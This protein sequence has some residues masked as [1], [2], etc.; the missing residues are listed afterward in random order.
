MVII[1]LTKFSVGNYRLAAALYLFLVYALGVFFKSAWSDDYSSLLDPEGHRVH[2]IKDG[3]LLH[4]ASIDFFYSHFN[5]VQSLTFIRMFGLAGLILLNDLLLRKF[6]KIESSIAV[7]VASTVAFTLPSFQFSAHWAGAFG[8][9]WTAYL[10]ILGFTLFN[11]NSK[12]KKFLGYLVFVLSLFAYPL[13]S[14]FIFPFI[15][16]L[17]LIRGVSIK[18]L[19]R[20][21]AVGI[22]LFV[23]GAAISFAIT[24]FYLNVKGLIFNDRVA[25]VAVDDIPSKIVFF[26]TRPFALT[27]RPFLIDSPTL[28]SLLLTLIVFSSFLVFLFWQKWKS[29]LAVS[30]HILTLN[31]FFIASLLP[32]L[33][34][35][36]NQIDMRLVSSN[37]WLYC[38]VVVFLFL[39]LQKTIGSK[40]EFFKFKS[41]VITVSF[42]IIVGFLT[43]NQ[44]F[45][46]LYHEP[47]QDK[48][49][50]FQE[51]FS[52]CTDTQIQSGVEIIR[53]TLPWPHKN[54]IGAYS[55]ST[56]LE[57]EWVP[58]SAVIQ[59]LKDTNTKI[60]TPP[61]L[62]EA[63]T[64]PGACVVSLDEY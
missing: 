9:A 35:S 13:M 63:N 58:V 10:A 11:E 30:T 38:F 45:W 20:D 43:I 62:V 29:L 50:F 2:A 59:Y 15:Y 64:N 24:A 5:T 31:V 37:T 41:Q 55:Q 57:S 53:R 32:L 39:R 46:N 6:L 1:V 48:Q 25:L 12:L 14:F 28:S 33:V 56:D 26:F 47:F 21:L 51:Q 52:A 17:W 61:I 18:I 60:V 42:L 54:L 34:T 49:R 22:F 7:A 36:D 44:N 8:F 19:F 4:G 27:Y 3:R 16:A 23:S 40:V